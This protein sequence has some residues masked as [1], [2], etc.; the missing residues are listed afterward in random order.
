MLI[1]LYPVL[2]GLC[3][4]CERCYRVNCTSGAAY[5]LQDYLCG[6]DKTSTDNVSVIWYIG[7]AIDQ[8][9]IDS[10]CLYLCL[11]SCN[12]CRVNYLNIYIISVD[13]SL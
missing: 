6:Q 3:W 12:Y 9:V 1:C 5:K 10:V 8:M 2:K 7:N 11:Y 4:D 13:F